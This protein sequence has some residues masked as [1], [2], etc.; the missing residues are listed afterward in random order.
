MITDLLIMP[1]VDGIYAF[2]LFAIP[3]IFIQ[4]TKNINL[5]NLWKKLRRK[6]F[7]RSQKLQ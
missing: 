4:K 6:N 3:L 2:L 5:R 1:F 7:R